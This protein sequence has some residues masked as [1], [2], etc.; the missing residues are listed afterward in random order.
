MQLDG[1]QH[2]AGLGNNIMKKT[3]VFVAA[4]SV[5]AVAGVIAQK[6]AAATPAQEWQ[7]YNHDLAG[8][9]FSP[10]TEIN[11]GNVAKL[12]PAWSY[13]LPAPPPPPGRGGGRGGP[14]AGGVASEAVP[15]VVG[16]VMYVPAGNSVVALEADT[17]K[18]IWER[19]MPAG[20][21]QVSRRGLGF[22]PGDRNTPERIIVTAGARLLSFDADGEAV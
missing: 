8:T 19:E 2:P 11:T 16:G 7:T 14:G 17:G 18:V 6:K 15:I 1:I 20:R 22:F 13:K 10:L 3:F 4:I 21:G 12:A 9:R 5:C